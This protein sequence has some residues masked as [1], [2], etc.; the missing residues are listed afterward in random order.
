MLTGQ[1]GQTG[2]L[3]FYSR[4]SAVM[5]MRGAV[6]TSQPLASQAGIAM[7]SSGGN[8][9]DAAVAAA[10]VLT[11]V[12]PMN[13]G[14][15]G[16]GFALVFDAK[17][18]RVDALNASGRAP[19]RATIEAYRKRGFEKVPEKGIL[20]VTVPGVVDG[21]AELLSRYGKKNFSEVLLAA[22]EYADKGF[23]VSEI[24]SENWNKVSERLRSHP[25]TSRVYLPGG[26]APRPGEVFKQPELARSLKLLASGGRDEFYI[27]ELA[28]RIADFSAAQE[29]LIDEQDL[30]MHRSTWVTP[31][32]SYYR[33]F[34][35]C[36][37]PPN[38]IGLAVLLALNIL[39][40]Y[41]VGAMEYYSD[42]HLH[43]LIEALKLSIEDARSYVA[44]PDK[45][46]IPVERLI[47]KIYANSLREGI[48]E[49]SSGEVSGGSLRRSDDT[50][51]ITVVDKEGNA[52]SLINSLFYDF[53]AGLV[54]DGT[55][56]CLQNR[57]SLFSLD[58]SHT[59]C[60]SPGKRPLHTLTPAL[61]LKNNQLFM[62]FGVVGGWMQP[63]AQ[64]Q[65]LSNIIDFGMNPQVALDAPRV[66]YTGG[67]QVSIESEFPKLVQIELRNRGHE[68]GFELPMEF[69]F[70]GGQI[71]LVDPEMKSLIAGSDPR[72]DG[73]AAAI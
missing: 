3:S 73:C 6:A 54:V 45:S 67:R 21:W 62:S 27:G 52:I 23:P 60:I 38:T 36:E 32:S 55:G 22:I 40:G 25:P 72:K 47:S 57:G 43:T 15:G 64:V 26:R 71:I 44:D 63:Q 16:D 48:A 12:E 1:K 61:V 10:A 2:G 59:N 39:E 30:A 33:G 13:I 9:A 14:L 7:L 28:K 51:Y 56:I 68:I 58:P 49:Q 53:G 31:I 4:R 29:G 70:G 69:S 34:Q 20:S 50:V 5:G 46:S 41:D 11:V 66:C 42:L 65:I 19:Q 35:V 24:I 18:G 37:M 8:A 17:S